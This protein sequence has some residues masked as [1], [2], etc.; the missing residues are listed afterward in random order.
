VEA[1]PWNLNSEVDDLSLIDIGLMPLPDDEWARGKCGLKALQ[2]M[3]LGIPP[4]VSP[5]GVNS[6]IV[7]HGEN[8]LIATTNDEWFD[9][10]KLLVEDE[11]LRRQLGAAAR[12]TVVERYSGQAWAPRF[13]QILEEAASSRL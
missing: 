6:D 9:S 5:V 3:A 7:T 10:I 8:G 1:L 12:E 2:Y 4:I 11:P 13:V